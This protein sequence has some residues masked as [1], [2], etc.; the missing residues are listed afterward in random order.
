MRRELG[1]FVVGV[2]V[3]A[4]AFVAYQ[5][6][7]RTPR[8]DLRATVIANDYRE[9]P[10]EGDTTL[11][12]RLLQ[13]QK[14]GAYY[15]TTLSNAG[16]E[17]IEDVTLTIP[18]AQWWCV[19]LEGQPESCKRGSDYLSIG[20]L[21]PLATASVGAWGSSISFTDELRRIRISHEKG[22]GRVVVASREIPQTPTIWNRVRDFLGFS[23]FVLVFCLLV[24]FVV[25][26][27]LE[28]RAKV[29]PPHE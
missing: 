26:Q 25:H 15:E 12:S 23:A 29:S 28:F 24:A 14:L 21:K 7:A 8:G 3:V 4:T 18:G 11:W 9:P 16:T 19:Q 6:Y 10:A 13:T 20:N 27:M 22:V 2:A 1:G 17:T 5:T